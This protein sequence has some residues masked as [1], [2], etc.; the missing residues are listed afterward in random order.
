MTFLEIATQFGFY[1]DMN[2]PWRLI[3]NLESPAWESNVILKEIVDNY[4]E[5][6]YTAQNV[7][8]KYYTKSYLYDVDT[9]KVLA[10]QFYNN[11]VSRNPT[12]REPI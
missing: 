2:V 3:A 7:F 10:M 9:I 8:D 4:F 6:G 12:V 1:V 5:E 11:F